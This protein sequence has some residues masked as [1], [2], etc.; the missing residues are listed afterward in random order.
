MRGTATHIAHTGKNMAKKTIYFD[1]L[2]GFSVTA[3]T[4]N[5]KVTDCKFSADDD[6]PAVG[7][8]Y[9]GRVVNVLE[10]MQAAFVDCGLERNCYL[11]A[12]DVPY[13][14]EGGVSGLRAGDELMVQIVKTPSGKK[15]AK[16]TAKP[17]F[18][19]KTLIYLPNTDFVGISHRIED[20]ELRESLIFAAKRAKR[21]GEGMVIRNAAPFCTYE[22][23]DE[24]LKFLR[25][26][27]E[28]TAEAFRRAKAGE[29]I[30]TDFT[31]PVRVMRNFTEYD[32]AK[33][34][35]GRAEQY[36]EIKELLSIM[37]GGRQI[38]LELYSGGRDMLEQAGLAAQIAEA[39]S[40]RVELKG[41]AYLI[42]ERTEALT[43]IDVNTGGF[44]GEDSL[45]YTVYHT[46]LAAARE[47][48][49]QVKLRNIGGL[50]VV[51][52]IDMAEEGHRRALVQEL[53]KALRSDAAPHRVLPMSDFGLVEF[54][55]KRSGAELS[56]FV[57]QP[58]TVCGC[59]KDY[60]DDFYM[61][62]CYSE[63]LKALDG[64]AAAATLEV[65]PEVAAYLAANR[66][67]G[68]GIREKFP[69]AEVY[70]MPDCSKKSREYF[71][72]AERKGFTP[73]DGAIKI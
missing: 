21:K 42:I 63:A 29:L 11:S 61:L 55:R 41:G 45:E 24:E 73:P 7:N 69:R 16:V 36:E 38:K 2:C 71:C 17:S 31:M 3:V 19:G 14:T 1:K 66:A 72:R 46:N 9:R 43:S 65:R 62:L 39:C 40:E 48:A 12:E 35:T 30:H 67:F 37:P 50:F 8:I 18:V 32:V 51:D 25:T 49:R 6:A 64:G 47:I 20:D 54:T 28:R 33:I 26:I 5:G 22:Q 58:C 27:Y 15:G 70:V 59:G 44:T 34:V 13:G 53:E 23:I 56:S 60:S 10:G 57:I 52:F 68:D 4:E